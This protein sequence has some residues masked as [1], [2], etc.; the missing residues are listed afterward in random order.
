MLMIS[1]G[2]KQLLRL[3][4]SSTTV[5]TSHRVRELALRPQLVLGTHV[6]SGIG[7]VF[8]LRGTFGPQS[9]FRVHVDSC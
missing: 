2:N 7:K 4:S 5:P 8:S 1:D 9:Y 6:S 3:E